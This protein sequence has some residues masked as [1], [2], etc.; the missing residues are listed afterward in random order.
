M[1]PVTRTHVENMSTRVIWCRALRGH[2]LVG[3]SCQVEIKTSRTKWIPKAPIRCA[4]THTSR[5]IGW[6][7]NMA[8]LPPRGTQHRIWSHCAWGT[9]SSKQWPRSDLCKDKLIPFFI[10][11]RSS[12]TFLWARFTSARKWKRFALC[13][14]FS[15]ASFKMQNNTVKTGMTTPFPASGTEWPEI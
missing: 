12:A 10:M 5:L 7:S 13:S 8:S 1:R 15:I 14:F 4:H 11:S 9:E 3:P 2:S 6:Y